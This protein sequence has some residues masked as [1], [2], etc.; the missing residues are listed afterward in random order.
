MLR[1]ISIVALGGLLCASF[2]SVNADPISSPSP[3]PSNS[4]TA[5]GGLQAKVTLIVQPKLAFTAQNY[6]VSGRITL[7]LPSPSPSTNPSDLPSSSPSPSDSP[8]A[9][10]SP[11]IKYLA[12]KLQSRTKGIWSTLAQTKVSKRGLWGFNVVAPPQRS[13]LTLRI[14]YGS[15]SSKIFD[16]RV[17]PMPT[18]AV[19]GPGARIGGVDISRY[20]HSILPLNFKQ[21]AKSGVGF[22]FIKASDGNKSDDAITRAYVLTDSPAAKTAGIY[23]GYYHFGRVPD[24]NSS[25]VL[26][27]SA[28]KQA[29]QALARLAELGGYDGKTLPYV[30]DIESAPRASTKAS[31]TLW[32]KTW[33]D[34]M[35]QATGR[36]SIIY[37]YRSFLANKFLTDNSTKRY[38][39]LHPLWLAHPGNPANPNIIPGKRETGIGCYKNAWTLSDC[40]AS[41]SFWQY[42]STGDREKY[43]IPW[44]PKSGQSCPIEAK[45]CSPDVKQARFHLDLNVF[46][47]SVLDLASLVQGTWKQVPAEVVTPVP[48][49]SP[50]PTPSP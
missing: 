38:L 15:F 11:S 18:V 43:G 14:A 50:N 2:V 48:S 5:S 40:T 20:Q 26:I 29:A 3:S 42:T 44:S 21:M 25:A 31:I 45:F 9:S 13:N 47:G 17:I 27:A 34:A 6:K 19:S 16:V 8:T 30:L 32:T 39:R 33:L 1:K 22:V 28:Q 35:F 12:A 46:N 4:A 41:W 10:P 49:P 23:V 24:S 36:R 7:T 37:S